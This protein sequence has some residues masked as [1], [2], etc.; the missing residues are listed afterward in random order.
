MNIK[1]IT[2]TY[3]AD[4]T[5]TINPKYITMMARDRR[6]ART[7]VRVLGYDNTLHVIETPSEIL[8]L[9]QADGG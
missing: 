3:G 2:L 8:E 7:N 4:R 9:I 6:E 1:F 5:T